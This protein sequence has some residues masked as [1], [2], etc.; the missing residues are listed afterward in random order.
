MKRKKSDWSRRLFLKGAGMSPFVTGLASVGAPAALAAREGTKTRAAAESIYAELKVRTLINGR[1]V[2]T[3]YSSTL[4]PPEVHRAMERASDHF[5]EIVELQKAVGA[6]LAGFAGTEAAVV[7]SGS[8]A[9]IAQATAGC[10]AGTDPEKISRLPDT[11]GLKNEVI[12]THRSV[13]DRSIAL[14]GAKLV[15]V[16]SLAELEAAINEKTAM[17]EY[18]YGDSGPV[19]LEDAIAVCKRK[20]VPFL[21]DAAA[22]C[23]PFERLRFLANL[24]PD[25][26]CVSGG[27]GLFGPQCSGILFGRKGL[28]EAALRNGSP[29]EG[30]ICRPMKVGKEEI[31]GVLA[32][33]EWSSKRDYQADCRVWESRIQHIVKTLSTIPGVEAEMYYRKIGNEVPHAAVRWDEQAFG[34]TKQDVVEALR[35]GEPQIEVVGGQSR[36]MVQQ[37]PASAPPP[38]KE[39]PQSSEPSRLISIVSNTLK[40]GEE[41]IIA[42]RLKEILKPA[43]D[44]VQSASRRA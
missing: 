44:R 41:K 33:V 7:C 11:E 3:F 16:K 1:G 17:M 18:E 35:R 10:I 27:K 29:Y 40:P 21:L 43:A 15:V 39:K 25:M 6:R 28:I 20:G 34:L 5:V 19:K 37:S 42:Q 31:V 22:M 32:A 36:E 12:L 4:M 24:G 38:T 9:C 8:A 14:A 26:F 23:P 30:S 13:W 2:A